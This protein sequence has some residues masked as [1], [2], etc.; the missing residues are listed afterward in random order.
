MAAPITI[1]AAPIGVTAL[2]NLAALNNLAV[3]LV[4]KA[5]D[6]PAESVLV[7]GL[8]DA[9]AASFAIAKSFTGP[10]LV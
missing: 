5:F 10:V 9:L 2:A 3:L 8:K 1:D 6:L 7:G 4:T